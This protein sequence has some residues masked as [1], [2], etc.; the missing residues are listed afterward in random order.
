MGVNINLWEVDM[1]DNKDHKGWA[2]VLKERG[3]VG[4]S[5]WFNN[6]KLREGSYEA[7]VDI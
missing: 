5:P 2:E 6:I 4:A 3:L 7:L 1:I